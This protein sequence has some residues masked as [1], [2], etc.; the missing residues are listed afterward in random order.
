MRDRLYIPEALEGSVWQFAHRPGVHR[1]PHLHDE[2]EHNLILRGTGAYIIDETRYPLRAGTSIWLYPSQQHLLV[3]TSDDFSM[4]IAVFRPRF[5]KRICRQPVNADL[6]QE[7]PREGF[8]RQLGRKAVHEL[9]STATRVL[10]RHAQP[11]EYNAL[12]GVL[13]L[14]T[15]RL[16]RQA[17][18][19]TGTRDVHPAVEKAALLLNA[20]DSIDDLES[21]AA[22]AGLSAARLSRLFHQQIGMPLVRYRQQC[23]LNRFIQIY[24]TGR[25][26]SLMEAALAAGFGSY[27]QFHRVMRR[28]MNM[29]PSAHRNAARARSVMD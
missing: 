5:L 24:D 9:E 27:A 11:D 28:E 1:L 2:L 14:S 12:L 4:A 6:C 26:Y 22:A 20:A 19:T 21:L 25:R 10:Q 18:A 7:H 29:S 17:D 15:W 13:L 16:H 8:C 23:C 3:E